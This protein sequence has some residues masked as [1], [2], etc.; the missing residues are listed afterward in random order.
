MR[1]IILNC[2]VSLDGFIEGPTGEFDWCFT[3]QDYGMTD[4]MNRIDAIFFGRKSYELVLQMDKR[5]YPDKVKYVFSTT[6]KNVEGN[7]KIIREPVVETVKSII[8]GKGKDIWLFGGSIL[9]TRL[10]NAGFV[11][12]MQLSVHPILLGKGKPL[13]GEINKKIHFELIDTKTYSTGL[14]Q[15]IYQKERGNKKIRT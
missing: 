10:L 2:A 4:F 9:V 12:E 7:A 5:P 15:L 3:D 14:V 1:K 6:I 11:D 8:A 13:F